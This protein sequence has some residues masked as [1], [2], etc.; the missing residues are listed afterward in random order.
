MEQENQEVV[1][2]SRNAL[3]KMARSRFKNWRGLNAETAKD[4][5][6]ICLKEFGEGGGEKSIL[7][8]TCGH[9]FHDDC[10]MDWFK[11]SDR[12]PLCRKKME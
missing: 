10:V 4:D 2:A 9:D 3:L 6:V 11:A 7:T 5:C 12:C 8:T 1:R